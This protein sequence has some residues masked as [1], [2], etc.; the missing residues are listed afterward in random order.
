M[1]EA[2]KNARYVILPVAAVALLSGIEWL[3]NDAAEATVSAAEWG[4][5]GFGPTSYSAAI[6]ISDSDLSLG[7]E[8]VSKGRDQWLRQESLARMYLLRS[9]LSFTYDELALADETLSKAKALAPDGSGPLLTDATFAQ[10]S[11]QLDR[12][13]SSLS[14]IEGTAVESDP[15]TLA[16]RASL[17]G[18][19]AFYRG[20]M[21]RAR[22]LYDEAA[23]YG[24]NPG[25]AYRFAILAKSQGRFDS[26]IGFL[27]NAAPDPGR[28]TPLASATAAMQ[29]GAVELARG[30]YQNA[31]AWFETANRQFPGF[32]LIEAHLAQ[33]KALEGDLAGAITDME[34]V[35][36]RAP[37]AE[38]LDALAMLL[39]VNGQTR[40]SRLW[41]GRSAA[42]WERRLEQL[43]E[44]AYGHAVEHELVFGSPEKA[45]VLAK[46]NFAARPFGESRIL[47]ASA[48]LSNA[49]PRK[50]IEHLTVAEKS[51]WRSAPLYALLAQAHELLGRP[52]EAAK[53][54]KAAEALNPR[55]FEQETALVWLSHG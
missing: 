20:D 48:Y 29:I 45:L 15:A 33:V 26:A 51:G 25:V 12:A 35:A 27:S 19:V 7:V 6:A 47:L 9:H 31:K 23:Q 38:V 2:L 53:A 55:I 46:S 44:A 37:A 8:R 22:A 13:E 41:A 24:R 32:W 36:R 30:D 10:M 17:K 39:R 34:N 42:I 43:P 21:A 49:A 5:P 50:A 18:D 3:S 54:R 4:Q 40:E 14:A 1:R 28:T 11:H 52:N 16:E